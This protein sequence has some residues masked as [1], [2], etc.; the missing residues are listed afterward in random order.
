M[1]TSYTPRTHR[2]QAFAAAL[3]VTL[4]TLGGIDQI[5]SY[6]SASAEQAVLAQLSDGSAQRAAV[7]PS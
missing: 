2:L 5:A 6:E 7:Q 3:L 1:S 4:C